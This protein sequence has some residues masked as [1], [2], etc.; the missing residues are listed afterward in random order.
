MMYIL[1]E[2]EYAALKLAGESAIKISTDELQALCTSIANTLPITADSDVAGV[3]VP[4]GCIHTEEAG[5]Y[6]DRCPVV[7][8]CPTK[9]KHWSK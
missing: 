8:I 9:H 3:P 5:W 2:S 6:C 1:T 7:K 4:W